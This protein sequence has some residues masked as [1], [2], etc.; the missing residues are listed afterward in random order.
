MAYHEI[1]PFLHTHK[2]PE[3]YAG[4]DYVRAD[5]DKA[6]ALAT[7]ERLRYKRLYINAVD[8]QWRVIQRV[9][10][11]GRTYG[12]WYAIAMYALSYAFFR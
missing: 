2:R 3:R 5:I 10:D 12:I 4:R 7:L 9:G 8:L 11:H 6:K 1:S